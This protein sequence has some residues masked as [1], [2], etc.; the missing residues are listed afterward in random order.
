MVSGVSALVFFLVILA[1]ELK[2]NH[3][4]NCCFCSRVHIKLSCWHSAPP[5]PPAPPH[6][7]ISFPH[8]VTRA[9]NPAEAQKNYPQPRRTPES[10]DVPSTSFNSRRSDLSQ[11]RIHPQIAP[12]HICS[13][14]QSL[15]APA[16]T[17]DSP[18]KASPQPKHAWAVREASLWSNAPRSSCSLCS[19]ASPRT[20]RHHL[21]RPVAV[22]SRLADL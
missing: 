20:D 14:V 4:G 15:K 19:T 1:L 16:L 5:A 8:A 22:E 21:G 9:A 10:P 2:H 17:K 12:Q 7:G 3:R 6:S 11:L 18:S 13:R